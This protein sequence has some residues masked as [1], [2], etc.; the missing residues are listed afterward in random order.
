ALRIED[1]QGLLHPCFIGRRLRLQAPLFAGIGRR[2]G[3]AEMLKVSVS[4]GTTQEIEHFHVAW[5]ATELADLLADGCCEGRNIGYRHRDDGS[6]HV[7]SSSV[8][9]C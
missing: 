9:S 7:L 2:A 4:A 6:G 5:N 3:G 1:A 8:P